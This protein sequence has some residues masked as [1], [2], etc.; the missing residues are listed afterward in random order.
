MNWSNAKVAL[1]TMLV[2]TGVAIAVTSYWVPRSEQH[3]REAAIAL[4]QKTQAKSVFASNHQIYLSQLASCRRGK[5][6][7]RAT[8]A[9]ALAN[10]KVYRVLRGFLSGAR[11]RALAQSQDPNISARSRL[12]AKKSL[13]SID[14]GIAALA[15]RLSIPPPPPRCIDVIIDP[16]APPAL[17]HHR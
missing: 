1:V 8:R 14:A 10:Q 15:V 9:N 4:S 3:A 11:P 17:P 12:G 5:S 2:S 7:R 13:V 6:V 16:N